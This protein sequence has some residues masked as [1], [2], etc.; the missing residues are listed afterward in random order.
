MLSIR[1]YGLERGFGQDLQVNC[2]AVL[3]AI[4]KAHGD[5]QAMELSIY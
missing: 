3:G 5:N 4:T 2:K 1:N